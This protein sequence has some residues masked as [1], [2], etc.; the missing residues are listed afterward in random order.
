MG[1]NRAIAIDSRT[2][3]PLPESD[4]SGR[5]IEVIGSRGAS[6]VRTPATFTADGLAPGDHRLPLPL[7]ITG[8][9]AIAALAAIVQATAG[10]IVWAVRQ[11]RPRQQPE[12]PTW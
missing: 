11:S 10:G 6:L 12:R 5:V 3:G 8:L 7:V 1:D 4:I 2:W 9:A